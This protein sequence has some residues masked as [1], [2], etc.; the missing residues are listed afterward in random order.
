MDNSD[1]KLIECFENTLLSLIVNRTDVTKGRRNIGTV[2]RG[3]ISFT[4]VF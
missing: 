4:L 1:Q 3:N 2:E